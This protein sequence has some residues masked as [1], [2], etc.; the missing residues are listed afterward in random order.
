M[1]K[2]DKRAYFSIRLSKSFFSIGLCGIGFVASIRRITSSSFSGVVSDMEESSEGGITPLTP[3]ARAIMLDLV[4]AWARYDALVGQLLSIAYN[5]PLDGS[6][7]LIGN[8]DTKT[9]LDRLKLIYEHHGMKQSVNRIDLLRKKHLELVFTRNHVAH[10]ICGGLLK[11]DPDKVVFIPF[12][13]IKGA[14]G[15]MAIYQVSLID[16][17]T[18]QR[19]AKTI[20]DDLNV[21]NNERARPPS[22]CPPELPVF[23]E[24]PRSPPAKRG[25]HRHSPQPPAARK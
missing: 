12:K 19:F 24:A 10:S 16:M 15:E 9:K 14:L 6:T 20:G 2:A 1:Q 22:K 17:Q 25:R 7:L 21:F 4:L 23:V 18:A 3:H 5:L 13:A 8:M 11:D